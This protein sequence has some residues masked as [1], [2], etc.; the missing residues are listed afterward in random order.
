MKGDIY[1][2]QKMLTDTYLDISVVA[3]IGLNKHIDDYK[4]QLLYKIMKDFPIFEKEEDPLELLM[5]KSEEDEDVS[6]DEDEKKESVE[7][8]EEFNQVLE[9]AKLC[10]FIM[11][12]QL[13]SSRRLIKL[14]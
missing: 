1:E 2:N 4:P 7:R 5:F 12:L 10:K 9:V 13:Q 14:S 8:S 6:V 11:I 3:L